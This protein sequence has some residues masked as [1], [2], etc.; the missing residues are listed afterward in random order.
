M[1]LSATNP[2]DLRV[3]YKRAA[4]DERDV[5]P[6]PFAQ[7]GRWFD[8]VV[9]AQL[10]EPNAMSL[11]TVDASGRPSARIVLLKAADG[12]GF[13]FYT[14]YQSRKA[15]ELP[16]ASRAALL[17]FWPELERQVRIEGVVEK[18]DEATADAYWIRRP[19]LSRIGAW[20][21]PQSESLPDRAALEARFAQASERYPDDSVPRPVHWGGYRVVPA[22]FEFWQGRASRLHDRIIYQREG[23]S[24]RIGRLAP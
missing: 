14:N 24:W 1:S 2:A 9:A 20:A 8:E 12:R 22:A 16:S 21:S 11:A 4:L 15:R 6:D 13:T 10:P 3:E 19:R 23:E 7:F 17:F 5:D 18:V